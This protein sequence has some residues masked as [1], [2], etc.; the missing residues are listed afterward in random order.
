MPMF[1]K[2]FVASPLF[3]GSLLNLLDF[4]NHTRPGSLSAVTVFLRDGRKFEGSIDIK[5]L[6]KSKP[7]GFLLVM[8]N[9]EMQRFRFGTD[10]KQVTSVTCDGQSVCD[11]ESFHVDKPYDSY[12]LQPSTR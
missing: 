10:P 3:A 11:T 5:D 8:K 4:H 1:R 7:D 2:P 12:R 6:L 9:G